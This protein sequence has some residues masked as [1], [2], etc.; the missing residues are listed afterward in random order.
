MPDDSPEALQAHR[1][2]EIS[3]LQLSSLQNFGKKRRTVDYRSLHQLRYVD[4][5]PIGSSRKAL[6][7]K[8]SSAAYSIERLILL[9][10]IR[11]WLIYLDVSY[12]TGRIIRKE[13]LLHK[14]NDCKFA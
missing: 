7:E 5:T 4:Q 10:Q 8:G 3:K 14:E 11:L 6:G 2:I 12:E 9:D 1:H 13:N